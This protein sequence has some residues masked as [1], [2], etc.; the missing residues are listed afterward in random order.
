MPDMSTAAIFGASQRKQHLKANR[1][2]PIKLNPFNLS[3]ENIE[4]LKSVPTEL[5]QEDPSVSRLQRGIEERKAQIPVELRQWLD[6]E[7]VSLKGEIAHC[8]QALARSVFADAVAKDTDFGKTEAAMKHLS[9]L[10]DLVVAID[11]SKDG[12]EPLIALAQV[13]DRDLMDMRTQLTNHLWVLQVAHLEKQLNQERD[14]RDGLTD[15]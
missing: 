12:F 1:P 10:K 8:E 11:A 13:K 2:P 3:R 4:A 5:F 6:S 15:D 14:R 7:L 9:F